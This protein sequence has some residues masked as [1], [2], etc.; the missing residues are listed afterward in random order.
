MAYGYTIIVRDSSLNA[1]S[2]AGVRFIYLGDP[3]ELDTSTTG[4][5][6]K[7]DSSTKI[8]VNQSTIVASKTTDSNGEAYLSTTYSALTVTVSKSGY[9][10][11]SSSVLPGTTT[12][13]LTSDTTTG[14]DTMSTN[15]TLQNI[16]FTSSQAT[17]SISGSSTI[18]CVLNA[19]GPNNVLKITNNTGS[20]ITIGSL[21]INIPDSYSGTT[22]LD[23]TTTSVTSIPSS[24]AKTWIS[25]I[26]YSSTS[27]TTAFD[28]YNLASG[29]SAYI[30]F[31]NSKYSATTAT[32]TPSFKIT[33]ISSG[34]STTTTYYYRYTVKNNSG[35]AISGATVD[36]YTSSSMTTKLTSKTTTSTGGVSYSTSAYSSLYVVISASGYTT[37]QELRLGSTSVS[38]TTVTLT[39][40]SYTYTITV[41]YADTNA[42]VSGASVSLYDGGLCT[43]YPS[44]GSGLIH[45]QGN[46]WTGAETT[47]EFITTITTNSSGVATYNSTTKYDPLAVKVTTS[48]GQYSDLTATEDHYFISVYS[49]V[50]RTIYLYA[51]KAEYINVADTWTVVNPIMV[52]SFDD[53]NDSTWGIKVTTTSNPAFIRT[54]G[55]GLSNFTGTK[56]IEIYTNSEKNYD[57]VGLIDASKTK[58]TGG[59]I[60]SN[61]N[62]I[63]STDTRIYDFTINGQGRGATP[64][65]HGY[66]D[67]TIRNAQTRKTYAIHSYSTSYLNV[68]SAFVGDSSQLKYNGISSA[69]SVGY[70]SEQTA[71]INTWCSFTSN[72]SNR[73]YYAITVTSNSLF[74]KTSISLK[75]GKVYYFELFS[76]SESNYDGIVLSSVNLSSAN[77]FSSVSGAIASVSGINVGSG[78]IITPTSDSTYYLYFIT[79]SSNLGDYELT[80]VTDTNGNI[81]G[82]RTNYDNYEFGDVL[83]DIYTILTDPTPDQFQYTGD[84]Y[85]GFVTWLNTNADYVTTSGTLSATNPGTYTAY[86]T[87]NEMYCWSDGT[88][89]KKT[90]TWTLDKGDG[91]IDF[92]TI[93]DSVPCTTSAT[94]TSSTTA[95]TKVRLASI[96]SKSG[97]SLTGSI[98]SVTK[99]STGISTTDWSIGYD[100]STNTAYANAATGVAAGTY[101]ITFTLTTPESTY[102]ES[103]SETITTTFTINAVTLS[104]YS[105]VGLTATQSKNY[106]AAGGTLT[107]STIGTYFSYKLTAT[108][109]YSNGTSTSGVDISN[110]FTCTWTI[111]KGSITNNTTT[112][113]VSK[114]IGASISATVQGDEYTSS[115]TSIKQDAGAKSYSGLSV[116]NYVYPDAAASGETVTP[117]ITYSQTW[118]WNGV[119][120]SGGTI[121]S[122]ATIVYSYSSTP[123]GVT[124][125]SS[126]SSNGKLTWSNNTSTS[127]RTATSVLSAKVTLNG[128]SVLIACKSCIQ[129][130][131]SK[132]YGDL[133]VNSAYSYAYGT[134]T[135]KG[136]SGLGP[137]YNNYLTY[138]QTWTWNGVSG[139]GGTITSGATIAYSY[140]GSVEGLSLHSSFTSN[141]VVNWANRGTTV[142]N[143]RNA[144]SYLSMTI[145]LNGKSKTY[146]CTNCYQGANTLDGLSLTLNKDT[147]AYGETTS[148]KSVTATYTSGSTQDVTNSATYTSG[149]TTVATITTA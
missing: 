22:Y 8:A 108:A 102:Y 35:V 95:T 88:T 45:D 110:S 61:S 80:D 117:S 75:K 9:T 67:G 3:I 18:T 49:S 10:S 58:L 34:S 116:S 14:G 63:S 106:P 27:Q 137:S 132:V 71:S 6:L 127:Q 99:S 37:S 81:T 82:T 5:T 131:G 69:Y 56:I 85:N 87:P 139:S 121:T 78:T 50:S 126:F 1:L 70:C 146:N 135:A 115:V 29:S 68:T 129:P 128:L 120:G 31:Y 138:S 52:G 19:G 91:Y 145:S 104:G 48:D 24:G 59:K 86:F 41:K 97:S 51:N 13:T 101:T 7:D 84:T 143:A 2:G 23:L 65:V 60:S 53:T 33:N 38:Y 11:E 96:E 148:P 100:S 25:V 114:T 20:S 21:S 149:D 112:S 105:N 73:Q 62:L 72:K 130:P 124:Y 147:I 57:G 93:T 107:T 144:K 133:E 103:A 32:V 44:S 118:T 4:S 42:V 125:D 64:Y 54:D 17:W 90:V 30:C 141:G 74:A 113:E 94:A 28:S 89:T 76:Y 136:M 134:V 12:I 122:G 46:L 77:S 55:L 92:V 43:I 123:T 36:F 79:N 119:S 66:D 47:A 142:G 39:T 40:A 111:T 83:I 109:N 98:S 16:T 26:S 140:T 15:V